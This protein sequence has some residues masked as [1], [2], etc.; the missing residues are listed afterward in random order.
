MGY[1]GAN[2]AAWTFLVIVYTSVNAAAGDHTL[3]A[4]LGLDILPDKAKINISLEEYT[5]AISTFLKS[6][7]DTFEPTPKLKIYKLG[8]PIQQK[9]SKGIVK[10][11]FPIPTSS[12]EVES[13]AL[14]LLLPPQHEDPQVVTIRVTQ[15]LSTRRRR[16]LYEDTIYLSKHSSKWCELDVTQAV[17]SWM[18]G[19]RNLGLELLCVG[20]RNNLNANVAAITTLTYASHRRVKRSTDCSA[21]HL[22]GKGRKE[23]CC[24][25]EMRVTFAKL[26]YKEMR[27]I[28]EPKIY[29]AG[30]CQGL[31]PPNYNFATNH[32]RIQGLIHQLGKRD[33]KL[34]RSETA[35]VPKT[36]CAP[37]K[38]GDL[39]ILMVDSKDPSKLRVETWENM[40]VLE[41]ACS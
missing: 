20:C 16:F 37:S 24:R 31:C 22:T 17:A 2:R 6:K 3:I 23:K 27:D 25:H 19:Q 28:V 41:C 36:C 18:R 10:M 21:R 30:Y 32:S 4:D 11:V 14:R 40:R 33:A 7:D 5:S 13:A 38:L 8:K 1:F 35:L 39:Q 12:D 26:G 34:L 9:L 29:E 15:I